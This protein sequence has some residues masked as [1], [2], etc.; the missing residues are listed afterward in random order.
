M[1]KLNPL[2]YIKRHDENVRATQK[3]LAVVMESPQPK[4]PKTG[5]KTKKEREVEARMKDQTA[6]LLFLEKE[7]KE[8]ESNKDPVP[9]S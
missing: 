4:I 8:T 7:K 9:S 1:P 5:R 2:A 3:K 6:F